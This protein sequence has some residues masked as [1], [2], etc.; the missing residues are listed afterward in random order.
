MR[1]DGWQLFIDSR[2][3]LLFESPPKTPHS[4]LSLQILSTAEWTDH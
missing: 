1:M 4:T 3:E 2:F